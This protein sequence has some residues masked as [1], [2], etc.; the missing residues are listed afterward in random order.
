MG[1]VTKSYQ[2]R[3]PGPFGGPGDSVAR[4]ELPTFGPG[5]SPRRSSRL[6][7][8]GIRILPGDYTEESGAR[9]AQELLSNR[10]LPTAVIAGNDRCALGLLD[11]LI[12]M[13][14][15]VP[16][17][18]SVVGYDDSSL[19]RLSFVDLTSVRQDVARMAQHTVE[20]AA[21]RLDGGRTTPKD[22]VL[23]PTL[24]IRGTTG[25]PR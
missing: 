23:N 2:R 14:I 5:L 25:P 13:K 16:A 24:V 22:I 4:D 3:S 21:E 11:S 10:P 12:R 19:A 15:E 18:V 9:A 8:V 7:L 20:A 6:L 1:W 17:D